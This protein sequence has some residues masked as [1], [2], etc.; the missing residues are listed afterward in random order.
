MTINTDKVSSCGNP[1]AMFESQP[2]HNLPW[3]SSY[4][5][6]VPPRK[7][8]HNAWKR[9]TV[10]SFCLLSSNKSPFVQSHTPKFMSHHYRNCAKTSIAALGPTQ[11]FYSVSIG[12]RRPGLESNHS[13]PSIP[14]LFTRGITTSWR[15]QEKFL[16]AEQFHAKVSYRDF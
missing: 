15:G 13:S 16:Q 5:S 11:A 12:V 14:R 8:K 10:A 3:W 1:T 2:R 7:S 4:I 6:T 9:A